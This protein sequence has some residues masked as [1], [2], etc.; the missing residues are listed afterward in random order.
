MIQ[1]LGLSLFFLIKNYGKFINIENMADSKEKIGELEDK[2][3]HL[4]DCL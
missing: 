1:Q 4:A 2:L 3:R